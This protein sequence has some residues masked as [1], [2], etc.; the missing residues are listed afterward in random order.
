MTTIN[1]NVYSLNAQRNLAKNSLGLSSALE[2]LSSG[3]RVNSAKDDA[4]GLAIGMDMDKAARAIS[5]DIRAQ[6]DEISKNQT[7]DGALSVVGDMALRVSELVKQQANTNLTPTQSG[8]ITKEIKALSDAS[9]DI[10]DNTKFN[11][12][13]VTSIAPIDA[14]GSNVDAVITAVASARADAGAAINTSEFKIQSLRVNYEAQMAAKGRIMD[15][16][17]AEET[18]RLARFQI[19]Q[20]AGTAMISQANAV[21]QNVLSLLR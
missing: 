11:D 5:A 12:V 14:T 1:T 15:A 6:S 20:Q 7:K 2:R 18:S 17:F 9:K 13:A 19:L 3:L 21:P 16:D 4:A 8:Y 10:I